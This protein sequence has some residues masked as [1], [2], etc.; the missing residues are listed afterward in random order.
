MN[1]RDMVLLELKA[2]GP[3]KPRGGVDV[4]PNFGGP[5]GKHGRVKTRKRV[6]KLQRLVN[7]R[8][9]AGPMTIDPRPDHNWDS[10][11]RPR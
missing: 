2:R 11:R 8:R 4:T 1:F 9:A 6:S 10:L 5:R 3:R 7:E